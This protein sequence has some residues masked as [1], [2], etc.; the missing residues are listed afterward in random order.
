[1]KTGDDTPY[2]RIAKRIEEHA[3]GAPK[4]RNGEGFSHAFIEYLKMLYTPEEAELVKYLRVPSDVNG[5]STFMDDYV[6]A[7]HVAALTGRERKVVKETFRNLYKRG[8]IAGLVPGD[9]E[10]MRRESKAL[11]KRLGPRGLFAMTIDMIGVFLKELRRFGPVVALDFFMGGYYALPPL[12]QM[13]NVY[14]YN[15]EKN[16]EA[17]RAAE[18]YQQFFIDDG[19]YKYYESSVGGTQVMRVVPVMENIE[20]SEKV[21]ENEEVWRILEKETDIALGPCPCRTRTERLGTRE[22][23]EK[24]PIGFCT[25]LGLAAIF[26]EKHGVARRVSREEAKKYIDEMQS[27]GLIPVTENYTR[28]YSHSVICMCCGCCCSQLRGRTRWDNPDAIAPS[29]FRPRNTEDCIFCGRCASKCPVGAIDVNASEK[30]WSIDPEK[31]LGCGVCTV[32]CEKGGL[33]L[34]RCERVG[35]QSRHYPTPIALYRQIEMENKQK[36]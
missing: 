5:P 10:Y 32:T 36:A 26:F 18:L 4:S 34:V 6:S 19:Y 1:M 20:R 8:H 24:N 7:A 28:P 16:E 11:S 17:L 29:S 21:L 3:C 12:P 9:R 15:L 31:C 14:Q 35:H 27:Y 25:Y 23:K 33:H 2:V 30:T 13:F 22:C